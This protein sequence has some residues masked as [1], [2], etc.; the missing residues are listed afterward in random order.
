MDLKS[1]KFEILRIA[2][3]KDPVKCQEELM[4]LVE[5]L[6]QP[7]IEPRTRGNYT[8]FYEMKIFYSPEVKGKRGRRTENLGRI[9][10]EIYQENP[11]K[12]KAMSKTEL[13]EV[14][15]QY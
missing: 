2:N 6:K 1:L 8:Y 15:E 3:I 10:K 7:R 11:G 5:I 4:A 12:F 14:L 13:K 9:K